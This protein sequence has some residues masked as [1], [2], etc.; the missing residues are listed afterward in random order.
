MLKEQL[1][2]KTVKEAEI[3][4]EIPEQVLKALF[5]HQNII[6]KCKVGKL[7]TKV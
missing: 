7:D 3:L 5:P 1:K 6:S 2:S 4:Q